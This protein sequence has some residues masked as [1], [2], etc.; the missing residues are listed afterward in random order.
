MLMSMAVGL[1]MD[2]VLWSMRW[3]VCGVKGQCRLMMSAVSSSWFCVVLWM[4]G[5]SSS[6]VLDVRAQTSM[7]RADAMWAVAI[8]VWPSPTMP[9]RLFAS[10]MSGV[11]Q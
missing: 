9:M 3:C 6:V 10:S 5:G 7:P 1:I 11:S 4:K 2:R 8:P